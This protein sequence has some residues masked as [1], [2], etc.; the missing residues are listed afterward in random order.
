MSWETLEFVEQ[1]CSC[2][3]IFFFYRPMIITTLSHYTIKLA[4]TTIIRFGN[5]IKLAS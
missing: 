1:S 5:D 3:C 2:N 4:F